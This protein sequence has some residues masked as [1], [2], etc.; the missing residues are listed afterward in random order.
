MAANTTSDAGN[1]GAAAAPAST[2]AAGT[3]MAGAATPV[4]GAATA[5]PPV[6]QGTNP[7]VVPPVD[8]ISLL[9]ALVGLMRQQQPVERPTPKA[10]QFVVRNHGRFNGHEVSRYLRQYHG[11]MELFEIS[12]QDMLASFELVVEVELRDCVREIQRRSVSWIAFERVL[13]EEF[14]E[15]DSE[16]V[17]RRTF[18]DWV[19]SRPGQTIGLNELLLEFDRRYKQLS[20]REEIVLDVSKTKLFLQAADEVS[21]DRLCYMLADRGAETGLTLDWTRVEDS[22]AILSRQKRAVGQYYGVHAY[23]AP[24]AAA[25]LHRGEPSAAAR[26]AVPV[27]IPVHVPAP[28]PAP[29]PAAAQ[30]A[31]PPRRQ[32]AVNQ[33]QQNLMEDLARQ[34][35][36]MRVE[37]TGLRREPASA[38]VENRQRNFPPRRCLLCDSVD[39]FKGECL[40]L[41][42]ALRDNIVRYQEGMLH[43]VAIGEQ[44]QT[45]W[46]KGGMKTLLQ[47][48]VAAVAIAD[49]YVQPDVFA[50]K[51]EAFCGPT[52]LEATSDAT[53]Q[54]PQLEELRRG[55]EQAR[56]FT[57]WN[58]PVDSATAKAFLVN[59]KQV[60]WADPLE[61]IVEEKRR[62]DEANLEL[63]QQR[64]TRRKAAEAVANTPPPSGPPPPP[65]PM[66]GFQGETSAAAKQKQRATPREKG[67]ASAYKLASDVEATADI[68][69]IFEHGLMDAR[70]EFSLR[71]LLAIE[72][73]GC[74]TTVVDEG[75]DDDDYQHL[76]FVAG[77]AVDDDEG[78]ETKVV[79]L[80]SDYM[81]DHWARA[82]AEAKICL[83][84]LAEHVKALVDNGSEINI[85]S[86]EVYDRGQWSIDLNHRWMIRGANN[87]KGDLYG[88]CPEVHVKVGDIIVNQHFFVQTSAPYPVLLGMPYI[89]VVRMKTKVMNDGSHYARIP[90]LDDRRSVQFLTVR[91]NHDRNRRNL[92]DGVARRDKV[93][94]SSLL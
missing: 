44:L 37:M 40:E 30:A 62:R 92:R 69:S 73:I 88:A 36:E 67:K 2:A 24:Q 57:G 6:A 52:L 8:T 5:P 89:T 94:Q 72:K 54:L 85:M 58:D 47:P 78:E 32:P 59:T 23:V 79:A 65:G 50:A 53:D 46:G 82:T 49:R 34:M 80:E 86:K 66:E 12:E 55:A 74:N 16:R 4:T 42:A 90:S 56:R 7:G 22:V 38:A 76:V 71:D 3:S 11:E 77:N 29:A 10:L 25:E 26:A 84:G 21:A 45:R 91:P 17:T 83:G 27:P 64:I 15:E 68:R 48:P 18:L 39:H 93:F 87:L 33:D 28:A 13:R 19:E 43:L 75:D 31:R 63:D 61:A 81:N 70:I 60:S 9:Q 41:R 14:L 51:V 1:P 20:T 35:R